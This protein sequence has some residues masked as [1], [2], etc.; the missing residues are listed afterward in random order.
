VN[1]G[2]S[3]NVHEVNLSPGGWSIQV[4]LFFALFLYN[5]LII[6]FYTEPF[7]SVVGFAFV[8]W[9][10]YLADGGFELQSLIVSIFGWFAFFFFFFLF[11][12]LY[13]ICFCMLIKIANLL[14]K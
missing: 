9:D 7:G 14:G 4:K 2:G 12:N 8:L 11:F 1:F 13:L 3:V 10:F 5:P 6:Y